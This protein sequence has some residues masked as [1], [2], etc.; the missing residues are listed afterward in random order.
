MDS[1]TFY[2]FIFL[3]C[4]IIAASV[5]IYIGLWILFHKKIP[6]FI[7]KWYEKYY[8]KWYKYFIWEFQLIMKYP[9]IV[10]LWIVFLCVLFIFWLILN[11]SRL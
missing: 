11:W 1:L 8:D 7:I 3:M 5:W 9:I 2:K 4:I 10:F 6:L